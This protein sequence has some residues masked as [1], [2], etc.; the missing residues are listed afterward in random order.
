MLG[1]FQKTRIFQAKTKSWS[2]TG[3]AAAMVCPLDV[4]SVRDQ[5][6]LLAARSPSSAPTNRGSAAEAGL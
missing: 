5:D 4:R 6:V 2:S 3:M 1:W